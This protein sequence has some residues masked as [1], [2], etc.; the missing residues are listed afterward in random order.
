MVEQPLQRLVEVVERLA[1][2]PLPVQGM[3]AGLVAPLELVVAVEIA[4]LVLQELLLA[5]AV[6]ALQ[7]LLAAQVTHGV[8]VGAV[9]S[10]VPEQQH[11]PAVLVEVV[12]VALE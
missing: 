11:P 10:E 7:L 1:Q 6:L 9:A 3:P 2:P 12:M 4:L 5:V 8:V